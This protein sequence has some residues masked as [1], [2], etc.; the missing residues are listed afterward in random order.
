MTKHSEERL[1][2]IVAPAGTTVEQLEELAAEKVMNTLLGEGELLPMQPV[3]TP[4]GR[5]VEG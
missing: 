3:V 5:P 1:S 4:P 2:T